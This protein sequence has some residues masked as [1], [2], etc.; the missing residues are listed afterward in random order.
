MKGPAGVPQITP[1]P[2][3]KWLA[4]T[5]LDVMKEPVKL[6]LVSALGG[7]PREIFRTKE[8]ENIPWL[9]WTPDGRSI[10]LLKYRPASEPEN[11]ARIRIL[12]HIA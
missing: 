10:W 8:D 12:C 2:D 6:M 1:S 5:S 9:Q 4:F 3:G 11:E 7:S